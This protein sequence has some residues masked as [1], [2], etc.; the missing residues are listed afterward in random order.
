MINY[1]E[2]VVSLDEAWSPKFKPRAPSRGSE[3]SVIWKPDTAN[4]QQ[5]GATTS[6]TEAIAEAKE[7][8]KGKDKD[9]TYKKGDILQVVEIKSDKKIIVLWNIVE[10][11]V[12]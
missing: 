11:F 7:F 2:F 12:L 9:F 5:F 3:Y 8:A 4:G 1:K 10:G 6:V